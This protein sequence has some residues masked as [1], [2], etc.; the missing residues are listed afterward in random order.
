ML[1]RTKEENDV[2]KDEWFGI[3]GIIKEKESPE[4]CILRE[5]KEQTG[6][7]LKSYKLRCIVTYTST[8]YETEQLCIFTSNDFEGEL[9]QNKEGDFQLIDKNKIADLSIWKGDKIF[10]E[11]LQK[12]NSFFTVKFEYD[13][14]KL[15]NYNLKEY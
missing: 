7:T 14:Q 6:L 13:G 11:K 2:K 15:V 4:E 5:V 8:K 9:I 10:L 1:H 3:G 12:D